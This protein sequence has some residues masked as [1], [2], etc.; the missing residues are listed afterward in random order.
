MIAA[1]GAEGLT[2]SGRLDE[3]IDVLAEAQ[4]LIGETEEHWLESELYRLQGVE[5][6]G[7]HPLLRETLGVEIPNQR[8]RVLGN[9]RIHEAPAL[10]KRP[11]Q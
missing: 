2:K 7:G 3:A 9:P 6:V 8:H 1:V 5:I 4:G 11:V 10:V